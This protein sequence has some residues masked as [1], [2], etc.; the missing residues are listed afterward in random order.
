MLRILLPKIRHFLILNSSKTFTEVKPVHHGKPV[1]TVLFQIHEVN[2]DL[3]FESK[4]RQF[5]S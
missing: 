1:R 5:L 3:S 4:G 2:E